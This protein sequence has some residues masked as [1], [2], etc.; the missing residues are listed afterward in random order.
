MKH[1]ITELYTIKGQRGLYSEDY[2]NAYGVYTAETYSAWTEGKA[3]PV[4]YRV[5]NG[6]LNV[7]TAEGVKVVYTIGE[8]TWY[9]TEAERQHVREAMARKREVM[10]HRKE[11]LAKLDKLST[12]NLEKLV[13][14]LGL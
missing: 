13:A 5:N 10:A 2:L 9:D 14:K 4:G 7:H 6:T 8:K 1:S 12:A 3:Y 11:L